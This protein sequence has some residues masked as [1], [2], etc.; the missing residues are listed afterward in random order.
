[1]TV[2]AEMKA[3]EKAEVEAVVQQYLKDNPKVVFDALMA[4]R[5]QEVQKMEDQ[6]KQTVIENYDGLFKNIQSPTL[7]PDTA[8]L[9]WLNLWIINVG[10]V[11]LW[12]LA[13]M[14]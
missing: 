3:D 4:Y 13:L 10:I 12:G 5:S 2:F 8:K 11:V 9:K 6:S 1:M 14:S 7:G